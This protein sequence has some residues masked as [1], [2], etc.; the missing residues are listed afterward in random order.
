MKILKVNA[1]TV[2]LEM[3][4]FMATSGK[5]GAMMELAN[6]ETKLYNDT[7]HRTKKSDL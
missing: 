6:G 2:G 5:P 4:Y 1:V 7:W 3:S